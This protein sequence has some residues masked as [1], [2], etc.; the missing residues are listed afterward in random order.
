MSHECVIAI[1]GSVPV[2]SLPSRTVD[3][4]A[5]A[6]CAFQL[7]TGRPPYRM[8]GLATGLSHCSECGAKVEPDIVLDEILLQLK[9]LECNR[10]FPKSVEGASVEWDRHVQS[11]LAGCSETESAPADEGAEFEVIASISAAGEKVV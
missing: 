6:F 4:Y 1:L 9:T 5:R 8:P 3:L 2:R 11:F 10:D 7:Q